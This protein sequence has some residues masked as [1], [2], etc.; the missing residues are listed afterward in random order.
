MW[1]FL[2]QLTAEF[3]MYDSAVLFTDAADALWYFMCFTLGGLAGALF[4]K[5]EKVA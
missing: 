3:S 2:A 4:M 1:E 5:K